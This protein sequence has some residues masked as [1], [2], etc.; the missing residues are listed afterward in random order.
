M[1]DGPATARREADAE[2]AILGIEDGMDYEEFLEQTGKDDSF[3]GSPEDG[4]PGTHDVYAAA[5]RRLGLAER[6]DVGD[7]G[8]A[9]G[10]GG[11]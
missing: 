5:M 6:Y 3:V 8:P 1:G 4:I 11:P 10:P 2:A 7:E 9:A